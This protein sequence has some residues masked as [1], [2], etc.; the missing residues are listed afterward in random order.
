MLTLARGLGKYQR[1]DEPCELNGKTIGIIGLGAVGK[2]VARLA[3]GF[4]MN[5]LYTSHSRKQEWEKKGLR[6]CKLDYILQNSDIISLHVPKNTVILKDKEFEM[7]NDDAIL[8][9]TCLG[10][11]F[12][13]PSFLKWI[14]KGKNFAIFGYKEELFETVK[15]LKNVIGIKNGTAGKTKESR[16]RLSE[17]VLNNIKNHLTN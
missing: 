15:N 1:R 4:N 6:F 10:V 7:I 2:Q 3:L 8:V 14:K 16:E 11:V 17:K 9:D 13:I 12:D 5:V